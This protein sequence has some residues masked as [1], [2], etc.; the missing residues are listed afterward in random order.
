MHSYTSSFRPELKVLA[1][2]AAVILAGEIAMR[3]VGPRSSLEL[4]RIAAI[5]ADAERMA[6]AKE[7]RVLVLGNSLTNQGFKAEVF[8]D[9]LRSDGGVSAHVLVRYFPGSV[10]AEWHHLFKHSYAET[11]HVPDVLILPFNMIA[12]RDATPLTIKRLALFCSM[13]DIPGVLRDE[14]RNSGERGT[15]LLAYLLASFAG[16]EKVRH[17]VLNKVIPYYREGEAAIHEAAT[18]PKPT[19]EGSAPVRHTYKNI[20][21]LLNLARRHRI[22]VICVAMPTQGDYV[23][24]EVFTETVAA[25]DCHLTDVRKAAGLKEEHF[26]DGYHMNPTGAAMFTRALARRMLEQVPPVFR[27]R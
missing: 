15:F 1:A 22:K 10:A 26:V 18:R 4:R 5:P 19:P 17:S 9:T 12:V 16:S 14:L 13:D 11:G 6:N 2:L 23:I 25:A 20:R 21:R 7:V 8:R 27:R 24:D 3:T